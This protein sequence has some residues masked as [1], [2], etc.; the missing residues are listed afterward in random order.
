METDPA[1]LRPWLGRTEEAS[2][3]VALERVRALQVTLERPERP[4]GVGDPLPPLW[5]WLFFWPLA[6]RSGLGR[7]GIRR[8]AAFCRPWDRRGACG[9]EAG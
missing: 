1:R 4:L 7:D 8:S 3:Q 6:P 2:N 5:H 9:P